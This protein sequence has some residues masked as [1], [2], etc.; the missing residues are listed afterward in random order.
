[1]AK[2]KKKTKKKTQKKAAKKIAKKTVRRS[3]P[4]PR[5][6]AAEK[7]AALKPGE[8]LD[9][10]IAAVVTAW[11][12]VTRK[13]RVEGVSTSKL[14]S[15]ARKAERA[16]AKEAAL[17]A[18]QEAKLA[19]LSD[20]RIRTA[21]AAYRAALRVKRIADAVAAE[22]QAVADAFETVNA[23]FRSRSGTAPGEEGPVE[24]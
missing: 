1:M 17:I 12:G 20:E 6:S 10:L 15:L 7:Q 11:S 5:L 2:S 16:A 18:K 4:K 22:D 8:N 24:A 19:P 3:Q 21:D 14:T 13:V 9:D 23:R